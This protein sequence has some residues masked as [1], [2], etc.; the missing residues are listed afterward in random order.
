MSYVNIGH[1]KSK[2]LTVIFKNWVNPPNAVPISKI[3][4]G[5]ISSK[6]SK[7]SI[8]KSELLDLGA[9]DYLAKPFSLLELLSRI[10]V[11]FRRPKSADPEGTAVQLGDLIIDRIHH[12][13]KCGALKI[14]LSNKEFKLLSVLV[15]DV[16]RV[17]S[18]FQLMDRV[19]DTQKD[20][21]SNVVEATVR[22]LRRKLEGAQSQ[23]KIQ[24][25]R[26]V[27]YWIEA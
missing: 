26:N 3:L 21:E 10:R 6:K 14:D 15:R 12:E 1:S 16:G 18:R 22:N 17:L 11:Q 5:L 4:L 25:K 13:V 9:D 24:S 2:S 8:R 23:V 27:G 19:W 20:I 7:S